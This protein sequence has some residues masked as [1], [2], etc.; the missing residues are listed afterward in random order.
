[1]S[2]KA[3]QNL[4][5]RINLWTEEWLSIN[6]MQNE[7]YASDIFLLK[8]Y[9][10]KGLY[11]LADQLYN[12]LQNEI[13]SNNLICPHKSKTLAEIAHIQYYSSS[14]NR[15]VDLMKQLSNNHRLHHKE[16]SLIYLIELQN[17]NSKFE[18][19]LYHEIELLEASIITTQ[20][21]ELSYLL[22]L[23]KKQFIDQDVDAFYELNSK[24]DTIEKETELYILMLTYLR[25]GF[26]KFWT[27]NYIED[28]SIYSE[29]AD[30]ILDTLNNRNDYLSPLIFHN[31]L[32][33]VASYSNYELTKNFI[34]KWID[35]INAKDKR[36][37]RQ[38]AEAIH[39]FYFEE[40][41]KINSLLSN[42]SYETVEQKTRG[43]ALQSIGYY[44]TQEYDILHDHNIN[45]RKIINRNT[46][47]MRKGYY[48]SVL[49][50]I[51]VID[52]LSKRKYDP[53]VV[54][55]L[56]EYSSLFYKSWCLKNV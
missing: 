7:K 18:N 16:Q 32:S 11:N 35:K 39:C 47:K 24:L 30:K 29:I 12:K 48:E 51:K 23:C 20:D 42:V 43:L 2:T 46:S 27:D 44:M 53:E 54:I 1:M 52:L 55:D 6:E 17:V 21:S 37:V 34:D 3:V 15:G 38:I 25:I 40:Y 41:D 10:R 9:N 4:F 49:N 26:V 45:L 8:A 13:Q 22:K 36:S 31:I 5:S 28:R 14:P 19:S 56:T 50:L 33:S